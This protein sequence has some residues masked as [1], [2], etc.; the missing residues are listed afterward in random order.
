MSKKTKHSAAPRHTTQPR[1]I[2]RWLA[3]AT[4]RLA[5]TDYPGVNSTTQRILRHAAA[6]PDQRA[7]ALGHRGA[8]QLMLQQFD[9]VYAA[10][11]QALALT[12]G[13]AYLW[14]NRG[15]A[16]RFTI[17]FGQAV[18]DFE[19]AA[20]LES[21]PCWCGSGRKYK[22]CHLTADASMRRDRS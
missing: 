11:S 17:R 19:R 22:Q 2:D 4:R 15:L 12:L 5:G 3:Q 21:D 10:L 13:D 20:A 1:D 6:S 18:R 16:S 8:A 9:A 14:Y 7:T